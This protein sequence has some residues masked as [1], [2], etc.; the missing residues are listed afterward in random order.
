MGV[1][2]TMYNVENL[3][4]T[5]VRTYTAQARQKSLSVHCKQIV[6]LHR[7]AGRKR[8]VR[9]H[10][11]VGGRQSILPGQEVL[12]GHQTLPDSLWLSSDLVLVV[13]A[14]VIQ[15]GDAIHVRTLFE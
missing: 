11:R 8:R 15:D 2:S 14:V 10:P 6:L 12:Y 1:D 5:R 7:S 4:R 9:R 13:F 3:T